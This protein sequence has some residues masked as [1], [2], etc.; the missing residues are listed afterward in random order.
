MDKS[1]RRAPPS[2]LGQAIWVK[3]LPCEID[4]CSKG[5]LDRQN[6]TWHSATAQRLLDSDIRLQKDLYVCR[7]DTVQHAHRKDETRSSMSSGRS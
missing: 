7:Y 6:H 3:S 1:D 5:V 4:I 2:G